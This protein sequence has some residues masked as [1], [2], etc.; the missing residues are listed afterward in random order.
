MSSQI[1]CNSIKCFLTRKTTGLI[2]LG[3]SCRRKRVHL[4]RFKAAETA[5]RKALCSSQSG[6]DENMSIVICILEGKK[7]KLIFRHGFTLQCVTFCRIL[8]RL[9]LSMYCSFLIIPQM[10][11]MYWRGIFTQVLE[12]RYEGRWLESRRWKHQT[13]EQALALPKVRVSC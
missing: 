2:C 13:Q 4:N 10:F 12:C 6:Q 9:M 5:R 11:L 8:I 1:K 3:K 7:S